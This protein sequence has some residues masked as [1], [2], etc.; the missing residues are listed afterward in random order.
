MSTFNVNR[1]RENL[2][3]LAQEFGFTDPISNL[4]PVDENGL[5]CL[6]VL[7]HQHQ[8]ETIDWAKVPLYD[9]AS[10]SDGYDS[11][12][13]GAKT[14]YASFFR[15]ATCVTAEYP[16]LNPTTSEGQTWGGMR[17]DVVLC[18]PGRF[19][20]LL[21]NKI[22]A[23]FTGWGGDPEKGQLALQAR[24]LDSLT[25]FPD[26]YLIVISGKEFFD[27]CWYSS[28]LYRLRERRAKNG[29]NAVDL[30]LLAWE[31]IFRANRRS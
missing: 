7:R 12:K 4:G 25:S 24:Y 17:S 1:A 16:L 23:S 31:D 21:E 5:S 13:A 30:R 22:G 3:N 9:F 19:V 28:E 29:K 26:R 14:G 11:A 6:L 10:V 20:A 18:N 8:P 2:F 27:N 15:F